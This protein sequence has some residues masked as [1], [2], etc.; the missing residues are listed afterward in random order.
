MTIPY[1]DAM[2]PPKLGNVTVYDGNTHLFDMP[3]SDSRTIP[4]EGS[5]IRWRGSVYQVIHISYVY[6]VNLD[7]TD[8]CVTAR[9]VPIFA[10][11]FEDKTERESAAKAAADMDMSDVGFARSAVRLKVALEWLALNRPKEYA[12][13]QKIW[14]NQMESPGCG[15]PGMD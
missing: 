8:V 9:Q 5:Y 11:L 15:W 7:A 2:L 6:S 14:H 3:M 1:T 13:I 10:F 12:K 4:P